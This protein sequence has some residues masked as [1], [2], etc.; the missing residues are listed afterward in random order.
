[1]Y[2]FFAD[3]NEANEHSLCWVHVRAKFKYASDI[4]KEKDVERYK[5]PVWG[6]DE[7]RTYLYDKRVEGFA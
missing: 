2:R 7:H 4:S 1:M 5:N 6:Y 3:V